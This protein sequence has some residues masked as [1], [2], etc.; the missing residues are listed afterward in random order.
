MKIELHDDINSQCQYIVING[1]RTLEMGRSLG[2]DNSEELHCYNVVTRSAIPMKVW[3]D[4]IGRAYNQRLGSQIDG[5]NAR[6]KSA[7]FNTGG[8]VKITVGPHVKAPV[9][10]EA[11]GE[12]VNS[13]LAATQALAQLDELM[14]SMGALGAKFPNTPVVTSTQI[15]P[16]KYDDYDDDKFDDERPKTNWLWETAM[17]TLKHDTKWLHGTFNGV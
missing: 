4:M 6:L 7:G 2:F 16:Y 17:S 15:M 14:K 11:I 13:K 8:T 3:D 10:G 12:G 1:V 5:A 9:V